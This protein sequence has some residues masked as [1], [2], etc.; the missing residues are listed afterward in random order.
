MMSNVFF[1]LIWV[2]W[3]YDACPKSTRLLETSHMV[4]FSEFE[5]N[6]CVVLRLPIMLGNS[7][8]LKSDKVVI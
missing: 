4:K 3:L 8:F 5:L 1:F 2:V 6:N 7:T